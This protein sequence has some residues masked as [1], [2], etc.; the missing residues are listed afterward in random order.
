LLGK[1]EEDSRLSAERPPQGG[2]KPNVLP[3][4]D[5]HV[6]DGQSVPPSLQVLRHVVVGGVPIVMQR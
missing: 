3:P 4:A 1:A 2:Q 5:M 6:P